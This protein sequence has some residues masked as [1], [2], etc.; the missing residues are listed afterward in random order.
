MTDKSDKLITTTTQIVDPNK[1]KQIEYIIAPYG[2]I[3]S[4]NG[5]QSSLL[6]EDKE[7]IVFMPEIARIHLGNTLDFK[8][9]K[10]EDK[11][12]ILQFTKDSNT[13]LY[14]PE[15]TDSIITGNE[16]NKSQIIINGM[17]IMDMNQ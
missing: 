3:Q 15:P 16:A 2:Q 10:I 5:K 12:A 7:F 6:I 13:V 4:I 1:I 9:K 17:V 8:I 11:E 14:I